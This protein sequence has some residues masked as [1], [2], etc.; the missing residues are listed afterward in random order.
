M[1]FLSMVTVLPLMA[2]TRLARR[3]PE[4]TERDLVETKLGF[5]TPWVEHWLKH[6]RLVSVLGILLTLTLSISRE[7]EDCSPLGS[8]LRIWLMDRGCRSKGSLEIARSPCWT[9]S[10]K[11]E[12]GPSAVISL[13]DHSITTRASSIPP[14]LS[15]HC[16]NA[17]NDGLRVGSP[18]DRF[19]SGV[20]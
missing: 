1:A 4:S 2:G 6:R 7:F 13:S 12:G 10:T 17:R 18:K 15:S 5:W 20:R 3:L 14:T 11:S 19:S 8:A 16:S 9:I